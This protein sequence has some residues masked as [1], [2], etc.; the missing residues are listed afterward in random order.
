MIDPLD[1]G[2]GYLLDCRRA[3]SI[4]HEAFVQ[5]ANEEAPRWIPYAELTAHRR[6]LLDVKRQLRSG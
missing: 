6:Q 2:W 1:R 3:P 4:G 5:F